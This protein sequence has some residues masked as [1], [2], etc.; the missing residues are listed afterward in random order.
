MKKLLFLLLIPALVRAGNTK[1]VRDA[2]GKPA[3][4]EKKP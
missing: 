4:T 2:N 3:Q 1:E